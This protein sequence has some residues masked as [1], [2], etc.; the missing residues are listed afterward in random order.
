MTEDGKFNRLATLLADNGHIVIRVA[1]FSRTAKAAHRYRVK[2]FGNNCLL[3]SIDQ[4]I[5]FGNSLNIPQADERE[6]K[7]VRKEV[8]LFDQKSFNE[9]IYNA[10]IHND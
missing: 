5:D 2:E 7:T 10:F 9:A 1:I 8:L 6:R 4:I 3:Y